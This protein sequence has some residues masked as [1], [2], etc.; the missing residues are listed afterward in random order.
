MNNVVEE[1]YSTNLKVHTCFVA[2]RRPSNL[3]Q[4][5]LQVS[6]LK[7]LGRTR[8]RFLLLLRIRITFLPHVKQFQFILNPPNCTASCQH[9]LLTS[10]PVLLRNNYKIK[11]SGWCQVI[12]S[13]D[14][15]VLDYR[16][17]TVSCLR[18]AF[19]AYELATKS[20]RY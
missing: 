11:I 5:S 17:L 2:I 7:I 8:I 12:G 13:P 10:L 3:L 20:V 19:H 15:R 14:Y 1:V 18:V 16:G 6:L 9:C 4:L